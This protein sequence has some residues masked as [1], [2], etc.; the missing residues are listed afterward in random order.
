MIKRYGNEIYIS[1]EADNYLIRLHID[2][3]NIFQIEFLQGSNTSYAFLPELDKLMNLL[4]T[5]I[6]GMSMEDIENALK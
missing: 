5:G 2:S 4:K 3:N 6:V 1:K